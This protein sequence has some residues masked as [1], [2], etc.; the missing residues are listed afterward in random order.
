MEKRRGIRDLTD[1]LHPHLYTLNDSVGNRLSFQKPA[2]VLSPSAISLCVLTATWL[3][4]PT[5]HSQMMRGSARS[6]FPGFPSS[7]LQRE[8]PRQ[9]IISAHTD[10]YVGITKRE[11]LSRQKSDVPLPLVSSIPLHTPAADPRALACHALVHEL[12]AQ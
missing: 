2:R 10:D 8:Q 3:H 4:L 5:Q 12:R 9:D 7:C 6:R 1:P 11:W